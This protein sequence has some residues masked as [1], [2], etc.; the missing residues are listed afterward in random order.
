MRGSVTKN[1]YGLLPEKL[2]NYLLKQEKVKHNLENPT[3]TYVALTFVGIMDLTRE[4]IA[5]PLYR[6]MPVNFKVWYDKVR[7]RV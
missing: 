1:R 3:L 2:I 5:K 6:S 7:Y 4:R